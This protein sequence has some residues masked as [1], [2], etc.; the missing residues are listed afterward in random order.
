MPTSVKV[1][2]VKSHTSTTLSPPHWWAALLFILSALAAFLASASAL[3]AGAALVTPA[4]MRSGSLLLRSTEDGRFVEAPRL[5]TDID[6]TVSGPTARAHVTQ[7]F[8]NPTDG[9]VEAVY[10]YPLPDGG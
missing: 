2:A 3:R 1:T 8:H 6:M 4:D 7:I 5:G 9:W 10:V